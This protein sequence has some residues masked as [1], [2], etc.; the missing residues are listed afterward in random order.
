MQRRPRV[1]NFADTIKLAIIKTT[2]ADLKNVKNIGN[3]VLKCNLYLYF[4]TYQMLI[5]GGKILMLAELK[6]CVM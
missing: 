3:Y 5:S 2:I 1:A 4:L 6:Q